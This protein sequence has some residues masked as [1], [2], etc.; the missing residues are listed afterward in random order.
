MRDSYKTVRHVSHAETRVRG[1]RFIAVLQPVRDAGE[2]REQLERLRKEYFDATHRCYAYRF[3][4][5]GEEAR[6][7]DDGEPSGTAGRPILSAL[8]RAGLTDVLLVVIRYFGGTKLGTGNLARAYAE[9]AAAALGAAET[10]ERFVV[11]AFRASFPHSQVSNVMRT[12]SR[13]GARVVDTAYDEE[14]HLQLEIRLSRT[15]E[16]ARSLTESTSGNIRMLP[17]GT[18]PGET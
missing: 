17:L 18:S 10:I 16:L 5:A 14:V 8:E 13:L 7:V 12:V 4:L 11:R 1:S 2:A 15:D 6:A 3:G 9:A